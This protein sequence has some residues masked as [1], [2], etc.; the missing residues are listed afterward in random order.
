M[1]RL[2]DLY[3]RVLYFIAKS[4]PQ[5]HHVALLCMFEILEVATRAD[6][7]SDLLQE[8]ERQ[9][10]VLLGLRNNQLG[11]RQFQIARLELQKLASRGVLARN[12]VQAIVR[13]D[14]RRNNPVREMRDLTGNAV[15]SDHVVCEFA[16]IACGIVST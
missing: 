11:V 12:Q 9:K 5:E 14:G 13:A 6:L 10:Q 2:E 4:D 15:L 7:K 8:L 3:E 1:L 16:A